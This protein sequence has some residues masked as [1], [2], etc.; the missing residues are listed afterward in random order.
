MTA[1]ALGYMT[2]LGFGEIKL[3]WS[4]LEAKPGAKS[5]SWFGV[6]ISIQAVQRVHVFAGKFGVG[7]SIEHVPKMHACS[8]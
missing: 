3:V 2:A 7:I 6:G 1:T 5:G 8:C 4:H